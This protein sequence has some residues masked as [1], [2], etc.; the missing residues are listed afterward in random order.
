MLFAFTLTFAEVSPEQVAPAP[1]VTEVS[2]KP[3]EIEKVL[4]V[5]VVGNAP[6]IYELSN[7]DFGGL[8]FRYWEIIA[9]DLGLKYKVERTNL[10]FD[11]S[12]NAVARGDYD[13][14]V[15][16]VSVTFDRSQVV[17]FSRPYF[18]NNIG[19]VVLSEP[20][21][22]FEVMLSMFGDAALNLLGAFFVLLF[23]FTHLFYFS[24]R[25]FAE[26]YQGG[27]VRGIQ[28]ACWTTV[29]SF[30]RDV[31]YD[32]VSGMGRFILSIWLV[33][34]VVFMAAFTAVVTST[35]TYTMSQGHIEIVSKS[36]LEGV[37]VAVAA[38]TSMVGYAKDFGAVPISYTSSDDALKLLREG[39]AKAI[40]G[41]YYEL[42]L[43]ITNLDE[44]HSFLMSPM[45]LRNDEF[46]F[47]AP[48][49]SP[50]IRKLDSG[51]LHL[52]DN[53][54]VVDDI[55]AEFLGPLHTHGCE[56]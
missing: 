16:P 53:Q 3:V 27:Y 39:K 2:S 29:S 54:K 30:L 6:F 13:I 55:C 1:V 48:E 24:E 25:R 17:D 26:R 40:L 19:L 33:L 14:L 43:M 10:S 18:V 38:E 45:N 50:I 22:F 21:S 35:M 34:S 15:G 8:S 36:D 52:Q 56:F 9:K 47:V 46:A 23:I 44:E 37:R 32:P 4:K 5:G 11:Q 31:L 42:K 12:I 41:N 51:I 49:G 28:D 20:L 7:G